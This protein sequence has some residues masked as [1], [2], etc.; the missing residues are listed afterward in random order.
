MKTPYQAKAE[1]VSLPWQLELCQWEI[2]VLRAVVL[3]HFNCHTRIF[4]R[5]FFFQRKRGD[6]FANMSAEPLGIA[7]FTLQSNP[8]V[9]PSYDG[10][11]DPVI[12]WVVLAIIIL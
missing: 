10:Q 8:V 1:R 5:F 7:R 2:R 6:Y 3:E 4:T 12:A 9:E 11:M